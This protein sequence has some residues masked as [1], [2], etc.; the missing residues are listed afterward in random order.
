M[1][2]KI[3][4]CVKNTP[5]FVHI[6]RTK[7]KVQQMSKNTSREVRKRDHVSELTAEIHGVSPR[8]V[9][10]V[11]TGERENESILT[12]V[13]EVHEG[14]NKLV[15]EIKQR[16]ILEEKPK[17]RPKTTLGYLLSIEKRVG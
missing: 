6:K 2:F 4:L 9:Q 14:I 17:K 15:E 3:C 1:Y 16:V 10:Y 13:M 5:I 8:L 12:T 7:I 11:R